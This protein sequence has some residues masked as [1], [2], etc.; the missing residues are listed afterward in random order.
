MMRTS[1]CFIIMLCGKIFAE[2]IEMGNGLESQF[3]FLK[4]VDYVWDGGSVRF[5]F[6]ME[7]ENQ[8]YLLALHR[9][10]QLKGTDQKIFVYADGQGQY[11]NKEEILPKSAREALLLKNLGEMLKKADVI[12]QHNLKLLVS[13]IEDRK[14]PWP[15]YEDWAR[16]PRKAT[17][18][19]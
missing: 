14:T 5:T 1:I 19:Q 8:G 16:K 10:G 2:Q 7:N 18:G 17:V 11:N 13:L 9:V 4:A 6:K 3:K 15:K 12:E